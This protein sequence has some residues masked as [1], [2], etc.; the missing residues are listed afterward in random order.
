MDELVDLK[1]TLHKLRMQQAMYGGFAPVSILNQIEDTEREITRVEHARGIYRP[2][3]VP[4]APRVPTVEEHK[5]MIEIQERAAW[6][7]AID[8]QMTLLKT[9]RGNLAHYIRQAR[10]YGSID[11]AP[12]ITLHGIN[13]S[14]AGIRAAKNALLDLE[15]EI[16]DLPDDE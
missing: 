8:H 3:P 10:A 7:R 16:A 14:R 2:P 1:R 15:I 13:E 11:L 12:P 9:Y 4:Y 6:Q 5:A